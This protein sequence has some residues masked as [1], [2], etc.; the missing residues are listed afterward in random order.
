[1]F[2]STANIYTEEIEYLS[3]VPSLDGI[4]DKYYLTF[5]EKKLVFLHNLFQKLQRG[6]IS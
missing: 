3:Q 1:M 2:I 6:G 4:T 5:T